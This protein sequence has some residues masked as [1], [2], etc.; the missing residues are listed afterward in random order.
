[1]EETAQ[2]LF[3]SNQTNRPAALEN[4]KYFMNGASAAAWKQLFTIFTEQIE[5]SI[6]S[7]ISRV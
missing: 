7:F 4:L 6:S 1:M 3:T 5:I 2:D